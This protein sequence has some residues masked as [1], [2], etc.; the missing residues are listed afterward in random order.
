VF[1]TTIPELPGSSAAAPASFD[2]SRR[3]YSPSR[4]SIPSA[5]TPPEG[6]VV[7]WPDF[8]A[9][10]TRCTSFPSLGP[11]ARAFT[12]TSNDPWAAR[13]VVSSTSFTFTSS[14]I[15]S[16]NSRSRSASAAATRSFASGS[17]TRSLLIPQR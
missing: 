7:H 10:I 6:D 1:N 3:S 4:S 16:T 14:R 13:S 8:T 5:T 2:T 15:R 11:A 17:R 9:L 12:V